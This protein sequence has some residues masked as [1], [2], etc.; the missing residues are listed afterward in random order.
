MF[1]FEKTNT[2]LK[3]YA[4]Y[5]KFGQSQEWQGKMSEKLELFCRI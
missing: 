1:K 4:L 3:E 2:S 5:R